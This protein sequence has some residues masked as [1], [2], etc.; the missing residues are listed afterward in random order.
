[1]IREAEATF[2][3]AEIKQRREG[4][5]RR[6]NADDRQRIDAQKANHDR[7]V[8]SGDHLNELI[9]FTAA[10]LECIMNYAQYQEKRNAA[11]P[12]SLQP[13][14]N[15]LTNAAIQIL[16]GTFIE[17]VKLNAEAGNQEIILATKPGQ[18][19]K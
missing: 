5:R 9:Q 4:V 19:K 11:R 2:G 15:A 3:N 6:E 13:L 1:M 12:A 7:K 17:D 18:R 16:S 10:G 8:M 14:G